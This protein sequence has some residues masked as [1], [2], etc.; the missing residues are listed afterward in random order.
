MEASTILAGLRFVSSDPAA[1]AVAMEA[2][3][4]STP[5]PA[6]T[7]GA[8]VTRTRLANMDPLDRGYLEAGLRASALVAEAKARAD[9]LEAENLKAALEES[10]KLS[11]LTAA[12]HVLAKFNDHSPLYSPSGIQGTVMGVTDPFMPSANSAYLKLL[13]KE[14]LAK[15]KS[16]ALKRELIPQ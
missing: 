12:L 2:E 3:A 8:M 7:W 15:D 13:C 10:E 4:T 1:T 14:Q 16:M 6:E 11:K 5:T 9:V